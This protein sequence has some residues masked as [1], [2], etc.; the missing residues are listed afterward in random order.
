MSSNYEPNMMTVSLSGIVTIVEMSFVTISPPKIE[1][2]R[3]KKCPTLQFFERFARIY[4]L[5]LA[6]KA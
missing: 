3:Y 4:V 5:C 1:L 6:V 2:K